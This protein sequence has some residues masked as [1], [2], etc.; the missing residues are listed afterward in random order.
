M[1]IRTE[2]LTSA[3]F[4]PFGDVLESEGITPELI[5]QGSTQK[6]ADQ[7][8]ITLADGGRAQIHIYR[9]KPIDLPFQIR[10]M[11][12]HALCSQ[13]FFPL[14]DRPFPIVVALP[15]AIPGPESIRVFLSNG[16]Q[17]VNLHPDVWHH[18]QLT[19]DKT[20]DYLVIDRGGAGDDCDEYHLKQ[21][22]V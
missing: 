2:P 6:F 21:E 22:V 11:E 17:G 16:R 18:Y 1:L 12:R 7:A 5:N 9:S 8:K 20:S 14:H 4:R 19:L 13:A 15:N 3:A 10:M